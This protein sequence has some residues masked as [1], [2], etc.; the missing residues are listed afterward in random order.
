MCVF[1]C[2][3]NKEIFKNSTIPIP[4]DDDTIDRQA[5]QN[6]LY[7]CMHIICINVYVYMCIYK[8]MSVCVCVCVCVS[9][10]VECSSVC[11]HT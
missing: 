1:D 11:A 9:L 10:R 3:D 7:V 8:Y 4:V 5:Y 6:V 2:Y